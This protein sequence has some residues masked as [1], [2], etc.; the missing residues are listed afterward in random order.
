MGDNI[1]S[2]LLIMLDGRSESYR[3]MYIK[4]VL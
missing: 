2:M 4:N 3:R 1:V